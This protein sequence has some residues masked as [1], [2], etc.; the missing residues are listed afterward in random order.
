MRSFSPVVSTEIR[1]Y[2]YVPDGDPAAYLGTRT[3]TVCCPSAIRQYC[4]PGF[5]LVLVVGTS[6][7]Q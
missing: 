6:T 3:G 4:Q 1:L 2:T 5:L 7:L